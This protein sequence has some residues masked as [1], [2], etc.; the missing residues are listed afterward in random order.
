[1]CVCVCVFVC[2]CWYMCVSYLWI[3]AFISYICAL[4]FVYGPYLSSNNRSISH[5]SN[6][7]SLVV[8]ISE[9]I[10]WVYT[11]SVTLVFQALWLARYFGILNIITPYLYS[12]SPGLTVLHHIFMREHNR[13]AK[14]LKHLNPHWLGE[15]IYQV[16]R[17]IVGA[18]NQ[19]ITYNEF[20]PEILDPKTVSWLS[21]YGGG[22][23]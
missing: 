16:T 19:H 2:V 20:L 5:S 12:V 13:I 8:C 17:K 23:F 7:L 18:M 15:H 14:I 4:P 10:W 22:V 11:N 21:N 3:F 1:M 6:A 9:Y